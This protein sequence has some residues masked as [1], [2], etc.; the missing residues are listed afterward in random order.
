[1]TLTFKT[2]FNFIP[3]EYYRIQPKSMLEWRLI[4]KLARNAKHV[5]AMDITLSHPLFREY[6]NIIVMNQFNEGENQDL[7]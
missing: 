5:K 3:Y 4:E 6:F 2:N 1:M 7:E